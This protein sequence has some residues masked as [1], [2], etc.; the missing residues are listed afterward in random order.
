MR[1]RHGI[2]L[3]LHSG[4]A[5][6]AGLHAS[7]ASVKVLHV[8]AGRNLYGGAQQVLYLLEGL[9]ARGIRNVLACPRDCDLSRAA[10][11]FAEVHAMPMYGDLDASMALRLFRLMGRVRPDIVHLHSR[12]GAD[13]MGGI[14]A[15]LRG[16]PVV[17]S[18]RQ[19]NPEAR[20]AV[21]LKYRLHDRVIAIS[22]GI[23]EVK[24]AEGLSE[25]KLRVVRSVVDARPYQGT[26]E[27][28]WLRA[29][30]SLPDDARVIAVIAQF[31]E[32]KGHLVLLEGLPELV[33]RFPNL[34][35]LFLGK[36]PMEAR[37][38]ETIHARGLDDVVRMPGFRKDLP[39]ILPALDLVVHP[40]LREG[41][42]VSLLQ[43]S[44]AGVPIVACRAGGI[45]EAVRDGE[46]GL[47]VPPRDAI[48][49]RDAIAH[50]LSDA[51]LARR[52]GQGGRDLI[53]REFSLDS[54]VEGNLAVYREVLAQYP[55]KAQA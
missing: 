41:L 13:V 20:L 51:D 37:L 7:R 47:L 48:A 27:P 44:A 18:R 9:H 24:L 15:R 50:V 36:G 40:A 2:E 30:F 16:L 52:L 49:L 11:P 53:A 1:A 23:A 34:R 26:P 39:R 31:I 22:Q 10:A 33:R 14:A 46:N 54:M 25:G 35:V 6:A 19:D 55:G 42:G 32:R 45:P 29:E 38:K 4:P 8:E 43:A 28:Q 17:Y 5:C 3:P 21:G 12:I